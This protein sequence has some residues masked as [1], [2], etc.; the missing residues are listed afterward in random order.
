MKAFR[1]LDKEAQK[2]KEEE[3]EN[4]EPSPLEPAFPPNC[5]IPVTPPRKNKKLSSSCGNGTTPEER[6]E[7]TPK[8]TKKLE[9]PHTP[10]R[11][12]RRK[13]LAEDPHTPTVR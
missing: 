13:K 9:F 2:R 6:G 1:A 3:V 7:V 10:P 8:K 5:P 11:L 4:E 12:E